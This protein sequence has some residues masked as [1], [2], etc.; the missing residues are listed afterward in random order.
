MKLFN[1]SLKEIDWSKK[2]CRGNSVVAKIEN[3][4]FY[5][6]IDNFGNKKLYL[7]LEKETL[8]F[9]V[10]STVKEFFYISIDAVYK[11]DVKYETNHAEKFIFHVNNIQKIQ[12]RKHYREY[13][14]GNFE[15]SDL[16]IDSVEDMFVYRSLIMAD[17]LNV[18]KLNNDGVIVNIS[19]GGFL[20]SK[21]KNPIE[22]KYVLGYLH[23]FDLKIPTL[24]EVVRRNS[25]KGRYGIKFVF[26]SDEDRERIIQ[27]IFKLQ[28]LYITSKKEDKKKGIPKKLEDE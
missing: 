26:V 24:G 12:R 22:E 1:F 2:I 21:S 25:E 10:V 19:G 18:F 15:F 3:K 11:L 4:T 17:K 28:R 8:P 13:V 23:I 6:K 7:Y 9:T 5:F 14:Y 27:N 20:L 16:L